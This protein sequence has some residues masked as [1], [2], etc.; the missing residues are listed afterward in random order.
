M[1]NRF[2]P[3]TF[4]PD[5][6]PATVPKM[7]AAQFG[8]ELKLLLRNGEQLLLTMFIPITLL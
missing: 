2:A 1:T 7:L 4:T 8:L 6:R 3:G 5:P